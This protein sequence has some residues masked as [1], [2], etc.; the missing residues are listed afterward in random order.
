MT[1]ITAS[2]IVSKKYEL[3]NETRVFG[4]RTLYRIK[5]LRDFDDIKAGQLGGVSKMRVISLMMAIAGLLIMHM[6]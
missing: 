1:T 3:T 4:N 6:F 2:K 5:A